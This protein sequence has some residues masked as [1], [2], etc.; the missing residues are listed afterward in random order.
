VVTLIGVLDYLTTVVQLCGHKIMLFQVT[1]RLNREA[2]SDL[3]L[4]PLR[5]STG[6]SQRAD[7]LAFL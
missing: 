5:F 6:G 7:A 3:A 1:T 2:S 4:Q